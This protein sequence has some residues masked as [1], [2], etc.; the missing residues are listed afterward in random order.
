MAG[1]EGRGPDASQKNGGWMA[2]NR[3]V[4]LGT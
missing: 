2:S 4:I 3:R 1:A